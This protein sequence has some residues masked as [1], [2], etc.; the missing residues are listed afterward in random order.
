MIMRCMKLMSAS[1]GARGAR[2][3]QNNLCARRKSVRLEKR[4]L[5]LSGLTRWHEKHMDD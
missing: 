1:A 3:L 4:P 5:A 2:P